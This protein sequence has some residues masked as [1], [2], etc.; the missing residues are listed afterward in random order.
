MFCSLHAFKQTF[1]VTDVLLTDQQCSSWGALY[2]NHPDDGRSSTPWVCI[3][4]VSSDDIMVMT[5][6]PFCNSCSV[7]DFFTSQRVT[8]RLVRYEVLYF[9][10]QNE[11]NKQSPSN[12]YCLE[13]SPILFTLPSYCKLIYIYYVVNES[14]HMHEGVK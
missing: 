8:F 9:I 2:Q 11:M 6:M 7:S 4:S 1:T 10:I 14:L 13:R 5:E 12:V 3:Q